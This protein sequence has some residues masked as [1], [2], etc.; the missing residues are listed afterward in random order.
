MAEVRLINAIPLEKEMREYARYIGLE[1]TN[2]CEST[3]ECCADMVSEAPAIDPE[4]L[5]GHAKQMKPKTKSELM[6]EWASQPGQLKKER[7]VKAVRKAMDDARAVMQDG[8]T[9]YVKKKTKARSMAKAEADPFA[10]LEGWE[11]MEQI[12]DAC[13]L[14]AYMKELRQLIEKHE[15]VVMLADANTMQFV[16]AKVYSYKETFKRMQEGR[17]IF[18]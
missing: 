7:E 13:G 6:A 10:E 12:Q 5:R 9:R 18:C 4:S 14:V 11:S 15:D 2:E 16:P 3:A 17:D 8:L 1:T